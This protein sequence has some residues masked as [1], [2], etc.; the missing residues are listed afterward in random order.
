VR[1]LPSELPTEQ[2][3]I[4]IIGDEHVDFEFG[5]G[6]LKVTP[7]HDKA[8]FD[9]WARIRIKGIKQGIDE[10]RNMEPIDIMN[11]DATMNALAGET[12]VGLDRS[13]RG[14]RVEL[15]RELKALEK[16]EPKINNVGSA[17]EPMC[18]SRHA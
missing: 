6:V 5:T 11:P 15:L 1:P 13:K 2:K 16:E 4:P 3:L 12:L 17:S 8:D 7:A 9:I 18:R 10:L 14:P